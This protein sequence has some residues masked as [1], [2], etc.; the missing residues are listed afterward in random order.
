[1]NTYR[2]L[3][4]LPL[5][6]LF[7]IGIASA[8]AIDYYTRSVLK[9]RARLELRSV[10]TSAALAVS[11]SR[12]IS[13]TEFM[14]ELAQK[15]GEA[16]GARITIIAQNGV[17]LGDSE[18][19]ASEISRVE[20][21]GSRPEIVSALRHG[22]GF[23][24]RYS[25]TLD[26]KFIYYATVVMEDALP[27][28]AGANSRNPQLIIR[29]ALPLKDIHRG[30]T[31]VRWGYGLIIIGAF[32]AV[33][34][35]GL[36]ATRSMKKAISA[37]RSVLEERVSLRTK[38]ISLLQ[39]MTA[40]L[41]ACTNVEEAGT[42]LNQILPQLLTGRSGAISI[43]GTPATKVNT[44]VS[45]GCDWPGARQFRANEC[46]ALRKGHYHTSREQ[47]T[48]ILCEHYDDELSTEAIC[49]PIMAQAET[50]GVL[51]LVCEVHLT[52]IELRTAVSAAEQIGLAL[53]NLK[54]RHDLRQEAIRDPLTGI[55]NRRYMMETLQ[56]EFSRA[57]RQHSTIALLMI[58]LDH[59]KK[60]NDT[61]GHDTGDLVLKRVARELSRNSRIEDTACRFGGEEFCLVCPDVS[62][63][64]AQHL[65]DKYLRRVRNL[66]I[67]ANHKPLDPITVSIGVALY[68]HHAHN[69][70]MLL[71]S[72][73]EALYRAKA[74]GRNRVV[75]S[76]V[77][78]AGVKSQFLLI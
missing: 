55:Y 26:M 25:T 14:D 52:E 41:N 9:D 67:S 42:I 56:Q 63:E 22:E 29:T 1:M 13:G 36:A 31:A 53:A 61:Y 11:A 30:L 64:N 73:D 48:N 19:S 70:E 66:D 47:E 37:E 54:L 8:F 76:L 17:V 12:R 23:S 43:L 72:A 68:P 62:L 3:V 6:L 33:M 69:V 7:A 21:H 71:K 16:S 32:S 65:A 40:L 4:V 44:L 49:I 15:I 24:E 20:N 5:A 58:D 50:F 74:E 34:I 10:A 77:N 28:G 75:V 38:E 60:F 2:R 35:L 78:K 46:W 18:L 39:N 59:F 45:W 51:H 57:A 27:D